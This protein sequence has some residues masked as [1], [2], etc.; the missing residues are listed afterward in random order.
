[1]EHATADRRA[2]LFA[3]LP[4]SAVVV[5]PAA[6]E[7][8]R[9]RDT[10]YP[11][12]QASDFWY[13]TAFPEPDAL[14]IL[15]KDQ[16][17]QCSELLLCRDKDPQAEVWQG[18]RYGTEQAEAVFG[19]PA[20][21]LSQQSDVLLDALRGKQQLYFS[22]GADPRFDQHV[23]A[24]LEQ[25]RNTPRQSELVPTTIHDLRPLLSEMRLIKDEGEIALM[26]HA[27]RISAEAHT[28][29]MLLC[30]PGVHEYQLEACILQHFAMQG[31]RF[32]AYNSI[33]GGG[34][35]A[36]ILHYTENSDALNDGDLV[37]ID[38][39]CEYQG[40]AADITRT[41]PVNGRFS[42][43]QAALYQLVLD[44]QLAALQQIKPG[45]SFKRA[46]DTA[47]SVLTAGLL[48]LGIL[49]GE[50]DTLLAEQ[51]AKPFMIHS[52]GHW[53]GLDVHD[54]GSYQATTESDHHSEP[55]DK[56]RLFEPGMVLTVEP[57]LYI[58]TG[59]ATDAK[60]WG[61]GIRIEDDVL[62][63]ETGHQVLTAGVPKELADIEALMA[64]RT[65]GQFD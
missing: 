39:G 26:Q 56:A 65:H 20:A 11:F 22:F 4:L 60:W 6:R 34:E 1:M 27:G 57:G 7:Q 54:V 24:A 42:P 36:C 53:L 29:A 49:Q 55:G 8:T 10:E 63:T 30:Q 14:L 47:A 64:G 16:Q 59:S 46:G 13:L 23:F 61:I 35:N 52:L 44:A 43:E 48:H 28:Q 25:I 5:V 17:G 41:F 32:A 19:V 58:P 40:Y 62:I 12:R 33:V 21:S 15:S 18:R 45:S 31:A 37:L 2:R 3:Q 51:A 38:A 50:L 9:S